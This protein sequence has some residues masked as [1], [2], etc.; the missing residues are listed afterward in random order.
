[1]C[2]PD[3]HEIAVLNLFD[4]THKSSTDHSKYVIAWV[5]RES[6]KFDKH[7]LS[8]VNDFLGIA[9]W[10]LQSMSPIPSTIHNQNQIMSPPLVGIALNERTVVDC[11]LNSICP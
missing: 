5:K 8:S 4:R 2:D 10:T 1:M 3:V 9:T 11:W 6:F 7:E